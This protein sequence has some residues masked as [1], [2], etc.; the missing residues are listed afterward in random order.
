MEAVLDHASSLISLCS[1]SRRT[2]PTHDDESKTP[3]PPPSKK[4][5]NHPKWYYRALCVWL[6]IVKEEVVVCLQQKETDT[7]LGHSCPCPTLTSAASLRDQDLS[8]LASPLSLAYFVQPTS[9]V[10]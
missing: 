6:R 4:Q 9:P 2:A 3:F 5:Q 1:V 7:I 8:F 10:I